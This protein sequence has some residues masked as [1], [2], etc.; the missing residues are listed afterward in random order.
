MA[1]VCPRITTYPQL[2]S[3]TVLRPQQTHVD[4]T[5]M[6]EWERNRAYPFSFSLLFAN[7][8]SAASH[9]TSWKQLAMPRTSDS[10]SRVLTPETT[11][12]QA[13][14]TVSASLEDLDLVQKP[15]GSFHGVFSFLYQHYPGSPFKE[16]MVPGG[17][18]KGDF[19][20]PAALP[21]SC[22]DFDEYLA[23]EN[24]WT[25]ESLQKVSKATGSSLPTASAW[26]VTA[27][28]TLPRS[29]DPDT[30]LTERVVGKVINQLRFFTIIRVE[31]FWYGA[32][33][34][35]DIFHLTEHA[36][37]ACFLTS[38]GSYL[39]LLAYNGSDDFYQ[40]FTGGPDG[41]VSLSARNDSL[42]D[43]PVRF[44]AAVSSDR[45]ASI[46]EVMAQASRLNEKTPKMQAFITKALA[47]ADGIK[48][49]TNFF[50]N[51][52]FCT[53][54]GLGADLTAEKIL[55]ALEKMTASGVVFNT[56]LID[57][58]WQTLGPTKL[59]PSEPGW[60]GWS[61][62]EANKEGFP[63][64]LPGL[65]RDIKSRY[66]HIQYVGVWHAILGYWAGVAHDSA[67]ELVQRYKTRMAK[68]K[69]RLSVTTDVLVI[70]PEDVH[71][72]YDD[73]YA[74]LR[75]EGV[76]FVKTDV[77]HLLSML[78]DPQDRVD[79][80]TAYQSAWTAAY[81]KHFEGR[82]IGCMSQIP[83][84]TF[85]SLLLQQHEKT[86]SD[87]RRI[88][89]ILVRN[90]DDFFPEIPGSHTLHIF[91]NAHNA[92]LT[93]HLNTLPDWDM[94]QTSHA[95]SSYH[96]AAR[97]ISG[98]AVLITDTPGEHDLLLI[99]QMTATTPSR[100]QIALRPS[101]VATALD[102]FERYSD[103]KILKVA[104]SVT[105]CGDVAQPAGIIGC[106][107]IAQGEKEALISYE[108]FER[109]AGFS[110]G[111][112]VVRSFRS[113]Q[114]F[115]FDTPVSRLI[116]IR[117]G[118]RDWDILTASPLLKL[119]MGDKGHVS[120][121]VLGLVDKMSGAAGVTK[122]EMLT[123]RSGITVH[124]KA[125]GILGIFIGSEK[126]RIAKVVVDGTDTIGAPFVSDPEPRDAPGVFTI[127]VS[128]WWDVNNKW[129]NDE[130]IRLDV[131]I[132]D[133]VSQLV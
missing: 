127:D 65:I 100:R 10:P 9:P 118:P 79:I 96:G 23:L 18:A 82:A 120:A 72:M 3:V 25:I 32:T 38:S 40:V 113:R 104:S 55:A 102:F 101:T 110:S 81:L 128:R 131:L 92:L 41:A 36:V 73:F 122:L 80:P 111:K 34:D 125:L 126:C 47:A 19:I 123:E 26:R 4:F 62:F 22:L 64:G 37:L 84:I 130:T 42:E 56:L 93:S 53:W 98:G 30:V 20:I 46:A 95:Y 50:D 52:G 106:F 83:Q 99:N 76:D 133:R 71:R 14:F 63:N 124:V 116:K 43:G 5:A 86:G 45:Q 74:F 7:A 49:D 115:T 29:Q 8:A 97:A 11:C 107:N 88:P 58:N 24:D 119:N 70:D 15:D 94:F 87:R 44:L 27:S 109:A 33:H 91:T 51:L 21:E 12:Q 61:R 129:R 16:M 1:G 85:H 75:G 28:E 77:Q 67:G 48:E 2:G 39:S 114:V 78:V 57:D 90:N 59:D 103:G 35:G 108:D 54:N 132:E 66:P 13:T 60:L 17:T 31:P 105:P 112:L 89:R 6:I 69:V 117:L 121:A 68:C